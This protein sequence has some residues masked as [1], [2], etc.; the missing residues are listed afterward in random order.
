MAKELASK[1]G[2]EFTVP[3]SIKFKDPK[4]YLKLRT[5]TRLVNMSEKASVIEVISK[6]KPGSK[7][8]VKPLGGALNEVFQAEVSGDQYVIKKFSDWF[9]FKWFTLNIVALGTKFFSVSGKAR[10]ANEYGMGHH[11]LDSGLPAQK[12]FHVNFSER[13]LVKEYIKGTILSETVKEFNAKN[14]LKISEIYF[15]VGHFFSQLHSDDIVL[16]DS[17]P[18]NLIFSNNENIIALDLEQSKKNGNKAW[19]V[20]EFL[21]YLGH[22]DGVTK[23]VMKQVIENFIDG[24][25][26]NGD[27]AVLKKASGLNYSKVFSFWTPPQIIFTISNML[28]N[29]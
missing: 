23:V 21:Y 19:D 7:I 1:I 25:I 26:R 17:K 2:R 11:L 14:T 29:A 8:Y 16:G 13:V 3:S 27:V 20:A 12:L 4:N 10:L 6:F 15:K 22:Y 5:S 9:G 18:E 28:K 24:Y